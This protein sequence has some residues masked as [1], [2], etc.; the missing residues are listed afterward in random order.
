MNTFQLAL[1]H[2]NWQ[3]FG[4]YLVAFLLTFCFAIIAGAF[5]VGIRE[6]NYKHEWI[7]WLLLAIWVALLILFVAFMY[8]TFGPWIFMKWN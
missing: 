7:E 8:A 6:H 2:T 5:I 3:A 4:R 1:F